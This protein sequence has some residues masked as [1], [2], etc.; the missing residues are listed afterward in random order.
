MQHEFTLRP[1]MKLVSQTDLTKD[2]G[3]FTDLNRIEFNLPRTCLD[4]DV[5]DNVGVLG[6]MLNLCT[7]RVLS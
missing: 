4:I 3:M 6:P 1:H 5:N 2:D 7:D